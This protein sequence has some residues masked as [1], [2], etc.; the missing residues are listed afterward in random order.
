MMERTQSH[1]PKA[2]DPLPQVLLG[3]LWGSF[4]CAVMLELCSA[5]RCQFIHLGRSHFSPPCWVSDKL[6]PLLALTHSGG[7]G[8][9]QVLEVCH[10]LLR[11]PAPGQNPMCDI[12]DSTLRNYKVLPGRPHEEKLPVPCQT[13]MHHQYIT[14][15][16]GEVQPR[17]WFSFSP[18]QPAML[19]HMPTFLTQMPPLRSL[20]IGDLG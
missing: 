13:L 20:L 9:V 17:T 6:P 15:S 14:I 16:W 2:G 11:S 8:T 12:S 19:T 3:I 5:L 4:S 18:P 7:K 1:L 10:S